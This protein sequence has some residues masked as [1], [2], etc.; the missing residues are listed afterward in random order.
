MLHVVED[1]VGVLGRLGKRRPGRVATGIER[2]VEPARPG[3]LKDRGGE[4]DLEKAVATTRYVVGGVTY[5]REVFSSYPDQVI[6]AAMGPIRTRED[7]NRRFLNTVE[8]V[9]DIQVGE[10]IWGIVTWEDIDPRTDR[11]SIYVSG[12][13]NAYKWSDVTGKF[14][15]GDPLGTGRHLLRKTLKLNFWR[16]GDAIDPKEKQIRFGIPGELDY[17]WVYR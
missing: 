8:M 11:F 9:R 6:P 15:P 14:K 13:T 4:L 2:R 3:A 12:L 10:T 16:P 1:E 17:E 5:T 7:P